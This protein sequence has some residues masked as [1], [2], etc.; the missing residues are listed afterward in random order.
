MCFKYP[1]LLPYRLHHIVFF[2]TQVNYM[3]RIKT[4]IILVDIL[5]VLRL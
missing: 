4:M 2:Q 3:K 1:I 5:D